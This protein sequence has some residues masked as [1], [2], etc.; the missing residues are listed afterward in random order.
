MAAEIP[1]NGVSEMSGLLDT[2][3]MEFVCPRCGYQLRK[4]IGWLKTHN[5]YVCLCGT[6]ILLNTDEFRRKIAE[7]ERFFD[8]G[9]S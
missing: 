8:K 4:T 5:H 2:E 6:E 3:S 1:T 7:I 9:G